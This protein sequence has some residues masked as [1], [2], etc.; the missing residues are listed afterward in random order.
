M[1]C[2]NSSSRVPQMR[3]PVLSILFTGKNALTIFK[4]E[5]P[6]TALS[7]FKY[8]FNKCLL[9]FQV[10]GSLR[11]VVQMQIFIKMPCLNLSSRVLHMYY[12]V[13]DTCLPEECRLTPNDWS[14][15][16]TFAQDKR[17]CQSG[18]LEGFYPS[19]TV[20]N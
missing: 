20:Y 3:H 8:L 1:P 17:L 6:L 19:R 15:F 10:R 16:L 4:F 13:S 18:S 11:Y 12:P 9:N 2:L 5:G 7:G 14:E